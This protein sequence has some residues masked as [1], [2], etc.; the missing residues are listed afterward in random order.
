MSKRISVFTMLAAL[1][2]LCL[3]TVAPAAFAGPGKDEAP[4][5]QKKAEGE[6]D[7]GD[8]DGD[9]DSDPNTAYTEDNDTNDG[10]ANNVSDEGDNRHP[11]GKDRSVENGKSGNQGNSESNPDDTNGPMRSEG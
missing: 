6:A 4:G 8:K 10:T 5:Q 2:A 3:M 1:F 9:A 7:S 11:S